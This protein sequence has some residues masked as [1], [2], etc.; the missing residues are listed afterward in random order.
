MW[1]MCCLSLVV[2]EAIFTMSTEEQQPAIE[3]PPLVQLS[4]GS[5]SGESVFSLPNCP[6]G[7]MVTSLKV[8]PANFMYTFFSKVAS[9]TH[10]TTTHNARRHQS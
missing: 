6:A 8:S 9:Q 10:N 2:T 4:F 7:E 3:E 1:K 5:P